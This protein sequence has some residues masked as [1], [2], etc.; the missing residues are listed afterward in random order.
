MEQWP[1]Q[2]QLSWNE[3]I[4]IFEMTK[5]EWIAFMGIMMK[6]TGGKDNA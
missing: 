6:S 5:K 3:V 2:Y 1:G 4:R